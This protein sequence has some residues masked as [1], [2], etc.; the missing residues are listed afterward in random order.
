[1]RNLRT[2]TFLGILAVLL[3]PMMANAAVRGPY[4][5]DANTLHLYHMDDATTATDDG[6]DAVDIGSVIGGAAFGVT[7]YSGFGECLSTTDTVAGDAQATIDDGDGVALQI[8]SATGAFTMEA[9]VN[10]Q[11]DLP[12]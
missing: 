2:V 9:L 6:L 4:L 12:V 11:V 7:S 5:P 1:M 10:L 8:A 3:A